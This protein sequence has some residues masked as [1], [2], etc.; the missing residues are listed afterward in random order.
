VPP[1]EK[2]PNCQQLVE[3]WHLEWYQTETPLFYRGLAALDCP[4][5]GQAVGF[6]QGMIGL[7]PAGVPL[8][9]RY[10]DKAA[11]WALLGAEFA[12]GTLQGYLY[13]PGPGRQYTSYFTPHEVQQADANEQAQK[14]GAVT[15]QS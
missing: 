15:C 4:L 9:R 1:N 14:G 8:V 10:V 13:T 6:Q 3:D 7:A 11:R 12:G 2:C 5:C